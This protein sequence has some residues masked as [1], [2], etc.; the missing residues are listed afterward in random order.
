[1]KKITSLLMLSLAFAGTAWAQTPEG[2]KLPKGTWSVEA[3]TSTNQESGAGNGVAAAIIWEFPNF[4]A[5]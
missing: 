4:L 5:F 3:S 1:M 2:N